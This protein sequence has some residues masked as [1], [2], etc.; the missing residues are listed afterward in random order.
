MIRSTTAI[1]FKNLEFQ[2]QNSQRLCEI[3]QIILDPQKSKGTIEY[4][5]K[6]HITHPD[7]HG[8]YHPLCNMTVYSHTWH[9]RSCV[10][11]AL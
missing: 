9:L 5:K 11:A 2:K 1:F 8:F 4:I 6:K 7:C 10:P 3:K